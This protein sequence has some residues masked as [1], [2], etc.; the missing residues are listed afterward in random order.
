MEIKQFLEKIFEDNYLESIECM[1]FLLEPGFRDSIYHE[2]HHNFNPIYGSFFRKLLKIELEQRKLD[3]H[4][5]CY[6]DYF[7]NFY[8][9]AFFIY[10]LKD[11]NDVDM[12]WKAKNVDFDSFCMFDIQFLAMDGIDKTIKYLSEKNDEDAMKAL[13]YILGCKKAGDFDNMEKWYTDKYT[14]YEK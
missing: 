4:E 13:E 9:C 8:W 11:I 1:N 12:L 2:L 14:Y 6:D 10:R 7:E 5:Y 3:I